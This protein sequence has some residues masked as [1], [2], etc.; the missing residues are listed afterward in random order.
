MLLSALLYKT[1][2]RP[3]QGDQ[4]KD[5]LLQHGI[6]LDYAESFPSFRQRVCTTRSGEERHGAMRIQHVNGA[7][8]HLP[9][10][11]SFHHVINTTGGDIGDVVGDV[12]SGIV[13]H[14]GGAHRWMT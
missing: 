7:P 4:V 3:I 13:H 8:V 11:G 10:A 14:M 1:L 6:A 9:V 12:V 5:Q 2:P